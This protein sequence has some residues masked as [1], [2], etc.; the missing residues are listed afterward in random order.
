ML[1]ILCFLH[2][3]RKRRMVMCRI[4]V[5]SSKHLTCNYKKKTSE[6]CLKP[7]NFHKVDIMNSKAPVVFVKFPTMMVNDT[8]IEGIEKVVPITMQRNKYETF[9]AGGAKYYRWQMPF[10]PAFA[11]NT[12]KVQGLTAHD[13]VVYKPTA[14]HEKPFARS[15]EYVAISRCTSVRKLILLAPLNSLHFECREEEFKQIHSAYEN[16][17][18]LKVN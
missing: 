16:F 18:K 1:V 6:E 8:A 10:I 7:D 14:L 2:A 4:V 17:R 5:F 9:K 15:L 12:H 13:G 11:L 3:F